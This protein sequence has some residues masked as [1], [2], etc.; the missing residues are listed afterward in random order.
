[1][2]WNG[3]AETGTHVSDSKPRMIST[4]PHGRLHV[5]LLSFVYDSVNCPRI[6]AALLSQGL[7]IGTNSLMLSSAWQLED[8]GLFYTLPHM[9]RETRQPAAALSL[10][11]YRNNGDL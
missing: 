10:F 6:E 3:D 5:H 7:V 11:P 2:Q 4:I 9:S 8:L 1:M